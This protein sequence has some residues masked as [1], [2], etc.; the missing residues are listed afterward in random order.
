MMLPEAHL[1][2]HSWMSGSRWVI[3]PS[4][5][6]RSW[7]SYLNS[8]SVYSC[9]LLISSSVRSMQSLPFI[10]AI[11]LYSLQL[12]MIETF[13]GRKMIVEEQDPERWGLRGTWCVRDYQRGWGLCHQ[14]KCKE[15][16]VRWTGLCGAPTFSKKQQRT[17][18]LRSLDKL[19]PE[20]S[21]IAI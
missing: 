4:W 19:W 3:T 13:K 14:W 16:Q 6:S 10:V 5:L 18:K 21:A 2:S 7:R 8:S 11:F 1:T 15:K 20:E 12:N 17:P 9:H